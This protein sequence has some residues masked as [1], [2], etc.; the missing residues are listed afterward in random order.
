LTQPL[1]RWVP[2][3]FLGCK[4]DRCVGLTT[5][6]PSCA[7]VLKSGSL[8]L[9]EPLGS[10]QVCN[11]IVLPLTTN[12]RKKLATWFVLFLAKKQHIPLSFSNI[13]TRM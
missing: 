3:I 7:I 10:V 12:I 9:L 6:P 5:L 13:D 8:I 1:T 11:G 4:G 2:G